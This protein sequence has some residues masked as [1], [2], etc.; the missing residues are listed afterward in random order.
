VTA[1]T[2]SEP[3]PEKRPK[4]T[5]GSTRYVT[6]TT[7]CQ[8]F[9]QQLRDLAHQQGMALAARVVFLGDGAAW[10]WELARI[11]FLFA[12]LILDFFHAAEHVGVLTEILFGKETPEAERHRQ[13]WVHLLKEEPQGVDRV[14]QLARQAMPK[15]GKRRRQTQKALAY[16]ENNRDKM[17]YWDYTYSRACLSAPALWRLA[18]RAWSASDSNSRECSGASPGRRTSWP[19]AACWRTTSSTSSG[20]TVTPFRNPSRWLPE[21]RQLKQVGYFFVLHSIWRHLR[22]DVFSSSSLGHSLPWGK[23]C[24]KCA[25]FHYSGTDYT[26]GKNSAFPTPN[27]AIKSSV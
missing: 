20:K 23:S 24:R 19:S 14:I 4:R 8:E 2:P 11:C 5:P 15:G 6:T 22:A 27:C 9:G 13:Q 3:A 26:D 7:N 16:F 1:L 21:C 17:R 25:I 12:L 18:A 10:V